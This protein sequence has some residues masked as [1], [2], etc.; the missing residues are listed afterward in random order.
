[1]RITVKKLS[2]RLNDDVITALNTERMSLVSQRFD[3]GNIISCIDLDKFDHFDENTR[4][5]RLEGKI[6]NY[7]HKLFEKIKELNYCRSNVFLYRGLR[8]N[9]AKGTSLCN[10]RYMHIY[11]FSTV[12]GNMNNI[13][14]CS[15]KSTYVAFLVLI[16]NNHSFIAH[17]FSRVTIGIKKC[18]DNIYVGIYIE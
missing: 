4:I 14:S 18:I 11:L 16:V 2:K 10:A 3:D 15:V 5:E 12:G 6:E 13:S 7:Q 1:M 17:E 9:E 8:Q